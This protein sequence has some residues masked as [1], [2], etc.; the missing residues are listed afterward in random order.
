MPGLGGGGVSG[1]GGG[2]SGPGVCVCLVWGGSASVP[3]GIPP[4]DQAQPPPVNRMTNRCKNITLATTS[5]R[6]VNIKERM[7]TLVAPSH[8]ASNSR[9]LNLILPEI[10][11]R[12]LRG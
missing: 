11:F 9:G 10:I 1:L 4:L 3:C 12:V 5:L 6:P 2:V 7:I 8:L